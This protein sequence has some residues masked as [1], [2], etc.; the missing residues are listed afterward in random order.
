[1]IRIG[2][3]IAA[4]LLAAA[5]V[6]AQG[7]DN[8]QGP[9]E[10]AVHYRSNLGL[11]RSLYLWYK[12]KAGNCGPNANLALQIEGP[13]VQF[14]ESLRKWQTE[15]RAFELPVEIAVNLSEMR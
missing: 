11:D 3:S 5:T 8:R 10:P 14:G 15:P 6:Q 2:I 4:V 7:P 12:G 9:Y 13:A 1:M